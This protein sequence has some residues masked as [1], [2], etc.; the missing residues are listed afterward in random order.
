MSVKKAIGRKGRAWSE[1]EKNF[2]DFEFD[3]KVVKKRKYRYKF[4]YK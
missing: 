3:T 4:T 2:I 1:G